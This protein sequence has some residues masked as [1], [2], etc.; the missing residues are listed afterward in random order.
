MFRYLLV[1]PSL[2]S[3]IVAS[4]PDTIATHYHSPA[5]LQS[6][7]GRQQTRGASQDQ[8]DA[9]LRARAERLHRSSIVVDTHNDITSPL[10]EQGFDL[11][12]R[13]DDP[14]AKV[15]T[16]TDLRRMKAGGL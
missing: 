5:T 4:S 3:L 6:R 2:L 8:G 16:H 12:M 1:I 9:A 7:A 14:T 13:G 15:K 10:L 11:A